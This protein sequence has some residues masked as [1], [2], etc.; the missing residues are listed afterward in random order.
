MKLNDAIIVKVGSVTLAQ[1]VSRSIKTEMLMQRKHLRD[2][3]NS[4]KMQ[5]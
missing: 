4:V 5:E 2:I 1:A 3:I